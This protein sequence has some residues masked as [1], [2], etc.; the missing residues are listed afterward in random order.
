[1]ADLGNQSA[2]AI[3]KQ[4]VVGTRVAPTT[5]DLLA[6]SSLRPNTDTYTIENPEYTGAIHKRGAFVT[7]NGGSVSFTTTI[8]GPGGASV[9]AADAFILGRLLQAAG[10]TENRISTAIPVAPEAVSSPTTTAVTLGAGAAGTADLY[11]A[12]L[13]YLAA[14]GASSSL[15]SYSAITDYTAGKVATLSETLGSAPTGNYQI[16]TQLAYQYSSG[17]TPPVLSVDIWRGGKKYQ[18]MDMVVSGCRINFAT[19]NRDQTA[20]CSIDWTL[21][22]DI[23]GV[24]DNPAPTIPA[25][26]A[27]AFYRDGD[28]WLSQK[29]LGISTVSLDIAPRVAYPPN[30]NK[31]NGNDPAQMV[32][33]VRSG[34][35]TMNQVRL[36][37]ID[38]DAL[39]NAQGTHSIWGQ[40]GLVTGN[41]VAFI[42]PKCRLA[43]PNDAGDGDFVQNTVDVYI[44][45]A[46]KAL[47]LI[48]PYFS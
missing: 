19:S 3:A 21:S 30:P 44:D 29:A 1:M 25:I 37:T 10:F 4:S 39:A 35:V 27:P 2:I 12:L 15:K 22:G 46:D 9:P 23:F 32:E 11:K 26:G 36:T 34:S 42:V 20:I 18:M 8:R 38:L 16:P 7:G 43:F 6:V 5:N 41:S 31:T 33:T 17:S 13:I 24:V 45:D 40:Y 14:T 47:A 48:F 28:F